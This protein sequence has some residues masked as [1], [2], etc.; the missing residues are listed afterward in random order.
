MFHAAFSDIIKFILQLSY[1]GSDLILHGPFHKAHTSRLPDFV[2][3]NPLFINLYPPF[4]YIHRKIKRSV[5]C[6]VLAN[7]IKHD[8]SSVVILVLDPIYD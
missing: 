2:P 1:I 4:V 6:E 5:W 8:N 7:K 3:T